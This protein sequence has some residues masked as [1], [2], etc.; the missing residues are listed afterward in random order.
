MGLGRHVGA[1]SLGRLVGFDAKAKMRIL[2][3][4]RGA[5]LRARIG[6]VA[7]QTGSQVGGL[8]RPSGPTGL[9]R[10]HGGGRDFGPGPFG[11]HAGTARDRTGGEVR[12]GVD[13]GADSGPMLVEVGRV[14]PNFRWGRTNFGRSRSTLWSIPGHMSPESG[15]GPSSI[16]VGPDRSIPEQL[17]Q[18]VASLWSP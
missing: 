3:A 11:V 17:R 1:G 14:R 10:W 8:G 6:V 4:L 7:L 5:S 9:P 12:L 16:D 2:N 13:L 18:K 15:I